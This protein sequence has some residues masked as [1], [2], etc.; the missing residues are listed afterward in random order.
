MQLQHLFACKASKAVSIG[1]H[2]LMTE[3]NGYL[4]VFPARPEDLV[5]IK[6]DENTTLKGYD[7]GSRGMTHRVRSEIAVAL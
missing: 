5:V 1:D 2:I 3:Q 7:F 6:G 4:W